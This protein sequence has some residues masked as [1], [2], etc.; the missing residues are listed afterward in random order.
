MFLVGGADIPF[1][2]VIEQVIGERGRG[3]ARG[4][5]RDVAEGVVAAAVVGALARIVG[6]GHAA[7]SRIEANQLMRSA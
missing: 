6:A 1:G 5:T 3:A 4:A 7:R 2:Q